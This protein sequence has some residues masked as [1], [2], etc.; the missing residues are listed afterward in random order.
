M[1]DRAPTS[2][3]SRLTSAQSR[4]RRDA[5]QT[6]REDKQRSQFSRAYAKKERKQRTH[7]YFINLDD[8]AS[9]TN[10]SINPIKVED[11]TPS[12]LNQPQPETSASHPIDYS[13]NQPVPS[14]SDL[15]V[16]ATTFFPADPDPALPAFI[17]ALGNMSSHDSIDTLTEAEEAQE[18]AQEMQE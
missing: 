13:A 8:T 11:P 14:P 16:H 10:S 3:F 9:E 1:Q 18:D 4:R 5:F 15:T 7:P 17:E 12:Q 6:R 2:F